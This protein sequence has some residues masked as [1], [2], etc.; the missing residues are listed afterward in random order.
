M[1]DDGFSL[2]EV[3]LSVA[4]LVMLAGLSLPVFASFNNRNDLDIAAQSLVDSLRRAQVYARGVKADDQWGVNVQQ[5]SITVFK[6][7][8]FNARDSSYDEVIS[9]PST[10]TPSDMTMVVFAKNNA[11]PSQAGSFTLSSSA[12][13]QIKTV[14]IN[15]KG[16]VEY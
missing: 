11:N 1:R 8:D 5:G 16:T 13:S 7:S 9:M 15:E 4:I 3:L 14:T 10:L 12:A 6:G 2:L